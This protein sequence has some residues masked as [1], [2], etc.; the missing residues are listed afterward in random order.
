MEEKIKNLSK[1]YKHDE[2][3]AY[4]TLNNRNDISLFNVVDLNLNVL[5][6]YYDNWENFDKNMNDEEYISVLPQVKMKYNEYGVC[7]IMF[8]FYG[9]DEIQNTYLEQISESS[10]KRILN[11]LINNNIQ[12]TDFMADNL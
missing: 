7:I 11:N 10:I 12:I 9:Y 1:Q 2:S 5:Y 8:E 4:I 3:Y 6:G